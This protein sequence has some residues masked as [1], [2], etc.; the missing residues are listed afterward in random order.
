[1]Q[2][3]YSLHLPPSDAASNTNGSDANM[4]GTTLYTNAVGNANYNEHSL[5]NLLTID[6]EQYVRINSEDQQMLRLNSEDLQI[7]NLSIS[8]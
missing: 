2:H 5:S 7:S 8:T 3:Q 4:A 1:M 6:S